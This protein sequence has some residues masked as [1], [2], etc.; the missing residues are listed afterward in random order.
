MADT[1]SDEGAAKGRPLSD[2][3]KR[4]RKVVFGLFEP[5]TPM[6]PI[7]ERLREMGFPA[8]EIEISSAIPIMAQPVGVGWRRVHLFHV[9]MIAGGVGILFGILLTAG[10]ALLYPLR[11]GGKPIVSPSIV[12]IISYEMMMLFAIVTTFVTMII[13]I[14][15][16]QRA[17]A[18]YDPRVDEGFVGVSVRINREDPRDGRVRDLLQGA[19]AVEVETE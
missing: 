13:Q 9:T 18:G 4:R 19:G 12:G 14:V 3:E 6:R 7:I 17:G 10:T 1:R 16:S 2:P 15:R 8:E 11:T 5:K